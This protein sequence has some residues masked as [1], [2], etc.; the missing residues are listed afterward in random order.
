MLFSYNW[1]KEF[2]DTA[3][4]PAE[5]S[6]KLTMAGIEVEDIIPEKPRTSGVVTALI[7]SIKKHPNAD[8][9]TLCEVLTPAGR[10]PIVCGA[11]N[12]KEGDKVALALDGANIAGGIT[13]KRKEIRGVASEGMMCSKEELGLKGEKEG[14]M[15]LPDDTPL[16]KDI[17]ELLSP[18]DSIL[19]VS[20]TPNRP[21]CMS[22][23]GLAREI[24]AITGEAFRDKKT[25]LAEMGEKGAGTG[26]RISITV[27]DKNLCRRYAARVIEGVKVKESPQWLKARIASHGVRSVN[28]IVDAAN[29][30]MLE[31]G[32][33]LHAF[34]LDRINGNTLIIR[35]AKEGETIETIDGKKRELKEGMLVISDLKGPQAIAG[36]MGGKLSEVTE[37]TSTILLESAWFDSISVRRTGKAL[38]LSSDSSYRFERGV[39]IEGV[40]KALD[41]VSGL[42]SQLS[43]GTAVLKG[44]VDIYPERHVPRAVLFRVKRG[45]DLLGIKLKEAEVKKIFE[46]LNMTVT[47]GGEK[48]LITAA[49]PSYR[50]DINIE[51][52]LVEEVARLKGYEN[53]PQ[54][55]PAAAIGCG[56]KP[57]RISI[58]RKTAG[59][60]LAASGFL[61]VINYSFV[62]RL[63]SSL[64]GD[65]LQDVL[66]DV[67]ILN[68]LTEEQ[69]VM[70]KS[71]LP[72]LFENL[73]FNLARKNEEVRIFEMGPV[74]SAGAKGAKG[75]PE[76]R[77]KASALMY[78]FRQGISWNEPKE[79][80]DFY[81][82]KGILENLLAAL[83]IKEDIRYS[84]PESILIHP[85]KGAALLIGEKEA[86]I[87]G[88]IHPDIKERFQLRKSA[89]VFEMDMEIAAE[90]FGGIR[91]YT[92]LPRFPESSRDIAFIV[93][94]NIPFGEIIKALKKINLKL[95]ENIELFDVYFGGN[96]ASG[97]RSIALRIT[98]RSGEKT[99]T[100]SEVDGIHSTVV[101]ELV[102]KFNAQLR[103]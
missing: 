45:E 12:M 71:L 41:Y 51:E 46:R 43:E 36:I 21:D 94:E 68:P 77:W 44:K 26:Q 85:G 57:G 6:L 100:S 61:E 49:P 86:A 58:M 59:D 5:L 20:I 90:K 3:L 93:D 13:V 74:F 84:A 69:V 95:I 81:D 48:G 32:Q 87:L 67:V 34:D 10:Y 82:I 52:D 37:K 75:A 27:E 39:D 102:D 78:G 83:G 55:L 42:I 2:T 89:Y 101:K 11:A 35:G 28:N 60:F 33:P 70:R 92:P 16:G 96:M 15:I 63:S 7:L 25:A 31:R 79:W 22:V 99:L 40:D 56:K 91:G 29:Y 8:R 1:L 65:S 54:T 19:S 62:S 18:A 23:L 80:V 24:S 88:E 9:L 30:A 66:K 4:T 98:Y 47:G 72:S 64:A 73:S 76:E 17:N 53:I 97:K 103:T 14:I 38:G 50:V